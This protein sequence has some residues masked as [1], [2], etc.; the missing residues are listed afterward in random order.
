MLPKLKYC[1]PNKTTL[2]EYK[3]KLI[4]LNTPTKFKT[5]QVVV[6]LSSLSLSLPTSIITLLLILLTFQL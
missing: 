5:D 6:S 1:Q 4:L 3:T 2:L